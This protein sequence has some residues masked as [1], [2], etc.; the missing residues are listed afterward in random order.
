MTGPACTTPPPRTDRYRA[1]R[2]P[3]TCP[4]RMYETHATGRSAGFET[5]DYERSKSRTHFPTPRRMKFRGENHHKITGVA[6]TGFEPCLVTVT[7]SS[8]DPC[9]RPSTPQKPDATKTRR[10]KFHETFLCRALVQIGGAGFGPA[11]FG[12][13]RV[14]GGA[15]TGGNYRR[16]LRLPYALGRLSPTTE[17]GLGEGYPHCDCEEELSA[18]CAGYRPKFPA[19]RMWRQV[20]RMLPLARMPRCTGSGNLCA[21]V[22]G[23]MRGALEVPML[24]SFQ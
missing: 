16:V 2:R 17:S 22:C 24:A 18:H 6:P 23:C 19:V 4:G 11:T 8:A 14:E 3:G 21:P 20:T 13:F 12:F 9:F 1:R 10:A 5:L 15:A 7:F